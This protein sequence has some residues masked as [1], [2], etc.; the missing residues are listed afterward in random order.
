MND[1]QDTRPASMAQISGR[2][3]D[4]FCVNDSRE[5]LAY[6]RRMAD[7]GTLIHLSDE[8]QS[9]YTTVIWAVDAT[10]GRLALDANP[11]QPAVQGLVAAGDATVVAY[12]DAIK[13]QFD[14]H[15]LMLVHGPSGSALQ[16]PLPT[17][18][19]R[20]Q[21]RS[22][23]RVRP[24]GGAMAHLRHPGLPDMALALR[25]LDVSIGGCALAVPADVP[26]FDAG[27]KIGRVRFE[28][29]AD[30]RFEAAL[31][32]QHVSGGFGAPGNSTRLGCAF[33]MLDGAAQRAL[34]R[35][36]DLSQRRHR[37]LTL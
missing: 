16:A 20:F 19:Y 5:V 36:I 31:T 22:S 9:A 2:A 23:F 8:G 14:L 30:T 35:F 12:L 26:V 24:R 37:L 28:L 27:V 18:M 21:R 3:I 29:D 6:C 25:V 11:A 7:E 10:S 33:G 1:F 15:P 34:Q 4:E 32:I 13:L 17:T